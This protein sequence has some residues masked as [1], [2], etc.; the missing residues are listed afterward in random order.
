MPSSNKRVTYYNYC[1]WEQRCYL[2]THGAESFLRS[3]QLCSHSTT[4]Q[5][6]MKPK[7]SV[8]CSQE[9]S[10]V[11]ILS[12]IN[13]THTIPS[14]LSKIHFNIVHAPTSWSFQWSLSF[15]L[16]HQYPIWMSLLLHSCYMP[17]PSH[18]SWLDHY[19]CRF[20]SVFFVWEATHLLIATFGLLKLFGHYVGKNAMSS[21]HYGVQWRTKFVELQ[22]NEQWQEQWELQC[23]KF[24]L[25][26]H[27][28]CVPWLI[29]MCSGLDNW[30]YWRLLL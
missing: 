28:S 30:I 11:P 8:P 15:W 10:T 19:P 25:Y 27:V 26:C 20:I 29:I 9:P 13:P 23:K 16:S 18:P 21:W 7:S 14:Y 24:Q 2:L 6:F 1:S 3:C 22:S 5:H 4:F 12:H 17:R